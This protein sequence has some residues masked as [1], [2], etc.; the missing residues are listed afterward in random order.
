MP[1]KGSTSHR[2]CAANT[3][4]KAN[5]TATT[6]AKTHAT[7]AGLA[8]QLRL[9]I[10]QLAGSIIDRASQDR[11]AHGY[12]ERSPVSVDGPQIWARP[13]AKARI[14][15]IRGRFASPGG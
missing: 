5:D 4:P 10:Q 15:C 14:I 3:A 12:H 2:P 1:T 13:G 8:E 9:I 11:C 6:D 7:C